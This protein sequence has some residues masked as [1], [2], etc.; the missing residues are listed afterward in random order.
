MQESR[1]LNQTACVRLVSVHHISLSIIDSQ[2][3]RRLFSLISHW[4]NKKKTLKILGLRHS[5]IRILF[6]TN[7]IQSNN[8]MISC[9]VMFHSRLSLYLFKRKLNNELTYLIITGNLVYI[10]TITSP[11]RNP[12]ISRSKRAVVI[13]ARVH[14]G[15]TNASWMMK[16]FLDYLTSSSADAKV[17]LK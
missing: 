3:K 10:L 11:S 12:E 1:W 4:K 5:I 17:R 7:K 16:G 15:E 2:Y 13:T 6:C 9:H 8:R 14:P